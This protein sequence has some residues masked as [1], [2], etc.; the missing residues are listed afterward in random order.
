[1]LAVAVSLTHSYGRLLRRYIL[2]PR[3]IVF[4]CCLLIRLRA[5]PCYR[6]ISGDNS[7]TY[8][9]YSSCSQPS[10]DLPMSMCARALAQFSLNIIA[11]EKSANTRGRRIIRLRAW[12]LASFAAPYTVD[13]P[14][15]VLNVR[16]VYII[17]SRYFHYFKSLN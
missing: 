11:N 12:A 10:S 13:F 5:Q 7:I 2:S 1:M 15:S 14:W 9:A 4:A 6:H 8:L 3:P 17:L 16:A